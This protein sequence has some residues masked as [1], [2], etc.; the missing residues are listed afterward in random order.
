MGLLGGEKYV[1]ANIIFKFALGGNFID[2]FSDEIAS[3][4]LRSLVHH[5]LSI[6]S[7][8]TLTL[9]RWQDTS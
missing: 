1:I 5:F 9:I 2:G 6:E 8:S 3:K 4:A 7:H